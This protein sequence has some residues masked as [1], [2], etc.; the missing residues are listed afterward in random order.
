MP[1]LLR[2]MSLCLMKMINLVERGRRG[3]HLMYGST[4]PRRG[5]SLRTMGRHMFKCG[6]IASGQDASTRA[7]VRVIM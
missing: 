4:L 3:A 6:L 7:D 1:S 2:V 5:W